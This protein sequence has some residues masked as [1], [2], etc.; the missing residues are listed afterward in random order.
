MANSSLDDRR[1]FASETLKDIDDEELKSHIRRTKE[2]LFTWILNEGITASKTDPSI[3]TGISGI[4]LVVNKLG[5]NDLAISLLKEAKKMNQKKGR[6][7]FLCGISGPL[8]LSAVFTNSTQDLDELLKL[9]DKYLSLP[10]MPD[11]LL[12][13]RVGYL[14]A[15]LYVKKAFPNHQVLEETIQKVIDSIIKSGKDGSKR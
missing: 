11:E 4:A 8:A 12:Y 1:A 13:G 5:Q 10:D 2:E 6:I 15:L 7:S 14:Y 3:Y 9:E